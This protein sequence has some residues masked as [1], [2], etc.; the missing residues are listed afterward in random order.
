MVIAALSFFSSA[1]IS[2]GRMAIY[3]DSP[4]IIVRAVDPVSTSLKAGEPFQYFLAYDK[5]ADCHPP[6]GSAEISYRVW[7]YPPNDDPSF[8]WIDYSRASRA[9]PGKNMRLTTPSSVPLPA[10]VPGPYGFQFR[11]VYHCKHASAP[12]TIDGPIIKFSIAP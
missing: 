12:Q 1:I 10:L 3:D 5:R 11:A 4:A 9:L 6:L 2:L 8:V 7:V